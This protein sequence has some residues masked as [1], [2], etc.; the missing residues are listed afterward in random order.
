MTRKFEI[1]DLG[2]SHPDTFQGFGTSYTP[3]DNCVAGI[4]DNAKAAY[5]DA[6]ENLYQSDSDADRLRLPRK[7]RGIRKRD[8]VPA[9]M[10]DAYYYVGIR[11]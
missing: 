6:L 1:V 10:E 9:G 7:P 4:G 11:W 2:I 8:R 5:E 3:F